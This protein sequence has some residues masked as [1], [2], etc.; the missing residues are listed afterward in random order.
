MIRDRAR[1]ERY[2]EAI[3]KTIRAGDVVVDIGTGTGVL[4]IAAAQAGASRVYAV[5]AASIGRVAEAMFQA[6]GY[7]DRI[8]LVEGNSTQVELPERADV[9]VSELIGAE[10]LGERI[11]EVTRDAIARFLKPGARMVPSRIDVLALPLTMPEDDYARHI[12][13]EQSVRNWREWY[14]IDFGPFLDFSRID[15]NYVYINAKDVRDWPVLAD[16]IPIAAID[17]STMVEQASESSR[18]AAFTQA[19]RLNAIMLCFKTQLGIL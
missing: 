8:T 7:G 17:L 2:I 1:T 5:E 12:L 11:Q 9:L 6:N 13:T 10:P 16:P 4:A 14:E 18:S 15:S 3:R 19:G